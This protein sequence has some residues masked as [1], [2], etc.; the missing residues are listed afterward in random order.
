MTRENEEIKIHNANFSPFL[1][2]IVS[3]IASEATG[4][5]ATTCSFHSTPTG[6]H[7]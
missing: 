4:M 5:I 3:L 6:K 7:A 2:V 1:T